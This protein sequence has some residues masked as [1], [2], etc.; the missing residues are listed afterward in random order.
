MELE[1]LANEYDRLRQRIQAFEG[2]YSFR[3]ERSDDGSP[4]VEFSDG[5][6][7][8]IVT[9]R[10]LELERDSTPEV[11][12]IAYWMLKNIT[13]WMG[14]DYEFRNRIESQDCRR[15]IFAHQVE[16]MKRADQ[17]FADRLE[18]EIAETLLKDP[19]NDQA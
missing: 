9:E 15:M 3:T 7:H 2:T 11:R 6:Y 19:Y 8:Y 13:F 18:R 4:H 17:Q 1:L 10:R 5:R 16:Q 14:V 12:E